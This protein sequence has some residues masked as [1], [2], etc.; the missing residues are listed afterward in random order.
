MA[1]PLRSLNKLVTCI[2][3]KLPGSIKAHPV[4]HVD[5]LC[6]APENP[7]PGHSNLEPPPLQ[8]NDQEEHKVEQVLAVKPVQRKLK[9]Q[10][11]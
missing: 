2:D 10:V 6:K 11:Q 1:G 3:F 9:Y 7:F 8:V 5:R 4:F